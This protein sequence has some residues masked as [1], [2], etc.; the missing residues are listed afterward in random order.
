[1][2][3]IEMQVEYEVA[4]DDMIQFHLYHLAHSPFGRRQ[5][6]IT[7]FV[8]AIAFPFIGLLEYVSRGK[9]GLLVI[10]SVVAVVWI[11]VAPIWWDWEVKRRTRRLMSEGTNPSVPI[12]SETHYYRSIEPQ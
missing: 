10:F 11:A 1:M 6:W 3:G 7:R 8:P 12:W 9:I 4:I 2:Q 5:K